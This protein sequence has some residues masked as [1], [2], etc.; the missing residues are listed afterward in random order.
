[1]V[2]ASAYANEAEAAME[3]ISAIETLLMVALQILRLFIDNPVND[4]SG[5]YV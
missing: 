4:K 2:P 1:M 3:W 5:S